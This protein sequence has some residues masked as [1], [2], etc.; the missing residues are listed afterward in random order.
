[1]AKSK[2][3]EKKSS[4]S[5]DRVSEKKPRRGRPGV[6]RDEI[7]GRAYHFGLVFNDCWGRIREDVLSAQTADDIAAA[8]DRG[9]QMYVS[10][11]VPHQC[12][13]ILEIVR[14]TTFPAR[15]AAQ[16]RY[17]A[18]SLAALG[19]VSPRRSRDI[20]AEERNRVRHK[21]IRQDYYIACTCGYE[22]PALKGACQRCGTREVDTTL[23]LSQR[24]GSLLEG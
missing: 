18:D 24:F 2:K 13:R 20:V 22:G 1:M 8:L 7:A 23:L 10:Y 9:A 19:Q 15:Q 6:R 17:L 14:E 11:F 5:L 12:Q 3:R 16:A 4:R 21:I